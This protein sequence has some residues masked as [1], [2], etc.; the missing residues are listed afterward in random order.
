M[1]L[2]KYYS[3]FRLK[4]TH[5]KIFQYNHY[6]SRKY[7]FNSL[8]P[9]VMPNEINPSNRVNYIKN[10]F[11]DLVA[12][13]EEVTGMDEVRIMQN[14]VIEAQEKFVF[15]Q[16]KRR[17]MAKELNRI[18][19][20]LKEIYSELDTTT[21][22]EER[23]LQLITAEHAIL[24]E[25]R[26]LN[27]EFALV[28]RE[29]RDGFTTLSACVKESHEKERAQ[30]ERTK[31]WSIIGSIIGTVIGI[32]GSSINNEFKMK[33]LRKLVYDLTSKDTM[34]FDVNT[35]TLLNQ[36][37]QQLSSIVTEMKNTVNTLVSEKEQENVKV[38]LDSLLHT[39]N[40]KHSFPTEN[41]EKNVQIL[42]NKVE[43]L[44]GLLNSFQR[45]DG[46]LVAIPN[47]LE[48]LIQKQ[49]Q[50]TKM[51]LIGVSVIGVVLPIIISFLQR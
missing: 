11:N 33:E 48:L 12:W 9:N 7:S 17:E 51:L 32:A 29:E 30:A 1:S 28:E 27:A 39:I 3:K 23:Y 46:Q 47:D 13:Y 49:S 26:K 35:A 20:K 43:E 14:K 42:E 18:Q 44:K 8:N 50:E 45:Y 36:H 22:G 10:K 24:K 38:Q 6:F 4:P 2:L 41:T 40:A 19:N 25:E 31:Y 21:R 15:A 37:E 5:R 16:E 34:K